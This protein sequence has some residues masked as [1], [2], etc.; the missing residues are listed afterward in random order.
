MQHRLLQFGPLLPS[1]LDGSAGLRQIGLRRQALLH[2]GGSIAFL[3][4]H[5]ALSAGSAIAPCPA[6]ATA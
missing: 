1:G 5:P 6:A 2:V 4:P 3:T